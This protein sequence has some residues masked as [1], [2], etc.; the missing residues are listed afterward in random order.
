MPYIEPE[1][2][3]DRGEIDL[4]RKGN[5]PKLAGRGDIRGA[6]QRH[7]KAFDSNNWREEM[8]QGRHRAI[9]PLLSIPCGSLPPTNSTRRTIVA[10]LEQG[11]FLE[12]NAQLN[13]L[14]AHIRRE[15]SSL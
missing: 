7:A 4:A 15:R 3:E 1:L 14:D 8:A 2:C 13:H 6:L 5:L 11:C 10:V 9:R 12:P